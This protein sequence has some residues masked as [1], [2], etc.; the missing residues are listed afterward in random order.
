MGYPAATGRGPSRTDATRIR[1][2]APMAFRRCK[3]PAL[4]QQGWVACFFW[5]A[6]HGMA[7]RS[8]GQGGRGES[9]AQKHGAVPATREKKPPAPAAF[10]LVRYNGSNRARVAAAPIC[11]L[12]SDSC[13]PLA[14]PNSGNKGVG[15][16]H[17]LQQGRINTF[18]LKADQ[19]PKDGK[20][21][22]P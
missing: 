5:R 18:Y 8:G 6:V 9:P 3:I 21:S 22:E 12:E 14:A 1:D 10:S 2:V 11:G 4:A 17:S 19:G 15:S 13:R 7:R 20:C 16:Y